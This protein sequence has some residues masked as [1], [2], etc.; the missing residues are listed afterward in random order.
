MGSC[1]LL[2]RRL[3]LLA[4]IV[5]GVLLGGLQSPA[6]A[7]VAE[8]ETNLPAISEQLVEG[9]AADVPGAACG[10]TCQGLLARERAAFSTASSAGQV[11]SELLTARGGV[12]VLPLARELGSIASRVAPIPTTFWV[13]W[14]IG[15]GLRTKI[16]KI[17]VPEAVGTAA[18][19]LARPRF[20]WSWYDT[21]LFEGD[22]P[23]I[24]P[25]LVLPARSFQ[26][27]FDWGPNSLSAWS[28]FSRPECDY[29]G[30][31]PP[32]NT[33]VLSRAIRCNGPWGSDVGTQYA[34]YLPET[35]VKATSPLAYTSGDAYGN[36]TTYWSGK[37]ASVAEAEARTRTQLED[38]ANATLR[39][40][41]EF[42]LGTPAVCDPVETFVCNPPER[43]SAEDQQRCDLGERGTGQDP[44]PTRTKT[45]NDP[46][47]YVEQQRFERVRAPDEA[48]ES[49][50]SVP[51]YKG[52]VAPAATELKRFGGWGWRH[53]VAK[54]GWTA[55]DQ[56]ATA[57]AL[58]TTPTRDSED[59]LIY[60]GPQYTQNGAI[61]RRKV[62]VRDRPRDPNEPQPAGIV[63]SYGRYF[64]PVSP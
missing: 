15:T 4:A 14:K 58:A 10:S 13:G 9:G 28:R 42:E 21:P 48:G 51:L 44:D 22:P 25:P 27:R 54:H 56:A 60:L 38:S 55:E 46:A 57:V 45:P 2:A 35:Q 3:T 53:I 6:W 31:G 1:Y 40:Y 23:A 18:E 32:P 33:V 64:G 17:G 24:D 19:K 37:P 49:P 20:Q 7:L 41:Y 61:C 5:I 11:S 47:L 39:Q 12:G 52:W 63:T 26:F 34:A 59:A 30:M 16:L 8:V 50:T 29:A 36:S 62:V 43:V